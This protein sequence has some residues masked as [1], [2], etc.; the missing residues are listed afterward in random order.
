[1]ED[2]YELFNE[3]AS[4]PLLHHYYILSHHYYTGDHYD[5]VCVSVGEKCK[6][7]GDNIYSHSFMSA[8]AFTHSNTL[9]SEHLSYE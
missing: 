1:M 3:Y 5:S 2:Y 4:I 9:S 6:N 7:A 8:L